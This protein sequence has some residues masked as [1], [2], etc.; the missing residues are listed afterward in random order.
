MVLIGPLPMSSNYK[1]CLTFIDRYTRWPEVI[2]L[3]DMT[4]KIVTK[5]F[6]LECIA[7]YGYPKKVG[8]NQG[9]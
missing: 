8:T 7:R 3:P 5:V 4:A 1:Y 2:P 6:A 9:R